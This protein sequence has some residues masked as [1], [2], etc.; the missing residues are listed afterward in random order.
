[1]FW[2]ISTSCIVVPYL[3][4]KVEHLCNMLFPGSLIVY[5]WQNEIFIAIAPNYIVDPVD[6]KYNSITNSIVSWTSIFQSKHSGNNSS[7]SLLHLHA[8]QA[9]MLECKLEILN[10]YS[11][12]KWPARLNMQPHEWRFSI[13]NVLASDTMVDIKGKT[14]ATCI[15]GWVDFWLF[16]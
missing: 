6:R 9:D 16:A 8:P 5:T 7:M 11:S 13:N 3:L 1:M 15:S 10:I 12:T 14:N 4:I 2:I